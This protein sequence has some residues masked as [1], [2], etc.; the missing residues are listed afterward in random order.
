MTA[1][2]A[3]ERPSSIVGRVVEEVRRGGT[4][5]SIAAR[6]GLPTDLVTA[7][8]GEL[9]AAGLVAAASCSVRPTCAVAATPRAD[10]PVGCSACPLAH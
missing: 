7:V 10:R 6:A 8:L 2:L 3:G 1:N 5:E 4:P 9:V